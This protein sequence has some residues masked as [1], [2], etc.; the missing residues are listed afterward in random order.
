M[1]IVR[2]FVIL[3]ILCGR[4]HAAA[5]VCPAGTPVGEMLLHV[6]RPGIPKP[7]P[8]RDVARVLPGDKIVYDPGP[9]GSDPR[10][11]QVA[12]ILVPSRPDGK[13]D[14]ELLPPK[15]AAARA[16]WPVNLRAKTAVY[17]YGPGGLNARKVKRYLTKDSALIEQLADY[18][19]NTAQTELLLQALANSTAPGATENLNA[20]LSGFASQYGLNNRINRDAPLDQQ[21]LSMF[22]S[23]NP[24][25]A[26]Y[27]PIS[28]QNPQRVV[29]QT[30]GLATVVAGMFLGNPVGLAAGGTALGINFKSILFPDTEFRSSFAQPAASA[31]S[32]CGKRE[33]SRGRTKLAYLWAMRVPDSDAPSIKVT[34]P[35]HVLA[36]VKNQVAFELPGSDA[37]LLERVR[38]WKFTAAG[39]SFDVP[40][41]VTGSRAVE[42][43]LSG[44]PSGEYTLRGTW[45]E[46]P[47]PV[48]GSVAVHQPPDLSKARLTLD[49]HDLLVERIG[50]RVVTLEGADFQFVEKLSILRTGDRFGSPAPVAFRLP[51]G[52]RQGI[53]QKIE[54]EIDTTALASGEFEL[55][56]EQGD[57]RAQAAPIQVLPPAPR[58]TNLPLRVHLD[59]PAQPVRME[60][61]GIDRIA[62]ISAPGVGF[63]LSNGDSRQRRA[64]AT[65]QDKLKAGQLLDLF[66]RAEGYSNPARIAGGLRIAPPRPVIRSAK[67]L[68]PS[69]L[70]IALRE[71][72]LPAG[73]QTGAVL[74][75]KNASPRMSVDV[76][77]AGARRLRAAIGE[78]RDGLKVQSLAPD[79]IYLA[80]DPAAWPAGCAIEAALDAGDQGLSALAAVGRTVRMPRVDKFELTDQ[81]AGDGA[82][83]GVLTGRDLELI[84]RAGWSSS[85]GLP[86]SELPATAGGAAQTLRI[87][88]PWPSPTPRAPLF[89]WLRGDTE[90]RS[91][92]IR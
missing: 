26:S 46:A 32:L 33:P 70:G 36:G 80:F 71:G 82:F 2:W 81:P 78:Q 77:C 17:V 22:R 14:L 48:E 67:I 56:F 51:A 11:G 4:L 69:G 63:R 28:P 39:K 15:P 47:F 72:E 5:P 75:I 10:K 89:L 43:D 83:F 16:E 49:T 25:L 57:G 92:S 31:I 59:E 7:L 54:A 34:A 30:A 37:K 44:V 19:Q 87:K 91:T 58:I 65:I 60:G 76:G 61:E 74:D 73:I 35:A 55:R 24:A 90:G 21:T 79:R 6:V 41:R 88:L 64:D 53:Q 66:V 29:S 18:A 42:F 8:L 23:L 85:T 62:M 52:P 20:A 68:P 3:A 9:S 13:D 40:A 86:V 45:D 27:D 50:K 38:G 1:R 84:E 12:M